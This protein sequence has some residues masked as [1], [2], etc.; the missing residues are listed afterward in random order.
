[1]EL[2]AD[3]N[4]HGGRIVGVDMAGV[5]EFVGIS[6]AAEGWSIKL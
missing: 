6:D 5:A 3:Q 4:F 1:L 2:V